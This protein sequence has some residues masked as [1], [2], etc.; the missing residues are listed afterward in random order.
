M[1]R[2]SCVHLFRFARH[3]IP[4]EWIWV[5]RKYS[6]HVSFN[7]MSF[8][9]GSH[10]LSQGIRTN[11]MTVICYTVVTENKLNYCLT[12]LFWINF[13][14]PFCWRRHCRHM[15][16]FCHF[17]DTAKFNVRTN[18]MKTIES[19]CE[20]IW[21]ISLIFS[22]RL[23]ISG[24]TNT[25]KHNSSIRGSGKNNNHPLDFWLLYKWIYA[26]MKIILLFA[27]CFIA[28]VEVE[29]QNWYIC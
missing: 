18:E 24:E 29:A 12:E 2:F 22:F 17:L 1:I 27:F 15:C 10:I 11:P 25:C 8:V 21:K 7:L 9:D 28:S 13:F 26:T 14:A 6:W 20:M 4:T 3:T 23:S 16:N 5:Q 19:I